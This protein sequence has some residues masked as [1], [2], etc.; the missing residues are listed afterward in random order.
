MTKKKKRPLRI[1]VMQDS[2]VLPTGF[3]TAMKFKQLK[4]SRKHSLYDK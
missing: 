4:L 2:Q 1:K 3:V